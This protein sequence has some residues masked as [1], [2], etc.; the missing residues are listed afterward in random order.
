MYRLLQAHHNADRARRLGWGG[1]LIEARSQPL[2][3]M[4]VGGGAQPTS[5]WYGP[6]CAGF[7]LREIG[8]KDKHGE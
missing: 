8:Q 7:A 6:E 2:G 4:W 3:V 5:L 1:H